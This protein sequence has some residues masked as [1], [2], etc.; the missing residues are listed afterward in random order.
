MSTHNDRPIPYVDAP[1]D[2]IYSTGASITFDG[3][4]VRIE[5]C[6]ARPDPSALPDT[7]TPSVSRMPVA[8]IALS[9]SV[10]VALRE[11]LTHLEENIVKLGMQQHATTTPIT[12][13]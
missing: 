7:V 8:R 5:F 3:F 1:V 6:L 10:A 4:A 2:E 9:P 11:A 13:Q 12:K